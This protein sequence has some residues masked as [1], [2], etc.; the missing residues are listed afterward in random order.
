MLRRLLCQAVAVA[1]RGEKLLVCCRVLGTQRREDRHLVRLVRLVCVCPA[2]MSRA[3][4]D[5]KFLVDVGARCAPNE[6]RDA[7]ASVAAVAV[8]EAVAVVAAVADV[9]A[10][11]VVVADVWS[12]G[13]YKSA[14]AAVKGVSRST[15]TNCT[16][17]ASCA[18]MRDT[19][20]TKS[21]FSEPDV[22][23]YANDM[24]DQTKYPS[25]AV[26]ADDLRNVPTKPAA[27]VCMLLMAK[28]T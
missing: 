25:A 28:A 11:A 12:I 24:K 15:S 26:P 1:R 4:P 8:V 16:V 7:A 14:S 19:S 20:C 10:V 13:K 22:K 6:F 21:S 18:A 9:A 5:H 3:R 23:T 2:D 27:L 17:W